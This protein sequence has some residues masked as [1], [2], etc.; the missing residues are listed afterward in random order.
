MRLEATMAVSVAEAHVTFGR[1]EREREKLHFVGTGCD[2]AVSFWRG[3]SVA[4]SL[5]ASL[6]AVVALVVLL[7]RG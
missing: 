2:D 3:V 7:V 4:L 6:W 5:S 1:V